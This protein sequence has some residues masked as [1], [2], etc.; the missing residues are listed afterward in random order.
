MSDP[1]R[2]AAAAL[3]QRWSLPEVGGPVIGRRIDARAATQQASDALRSALQQAEARGYEAGLARAQAETQAAMDAQAARVQHLDSILQLLATP[4]Q[5]LDAEVERDLL[6][7]TLAVGKQLARRELRIDPTQIIGIIRESL[8]QLPIAAREIRVHL[9]PE[10]AATVRDRLP[11]TTNGRAWS[12]VEDPTL[13]RGG[14]LVRTD[15]SQI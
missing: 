15:T 14:C 7:L 1:Q 9:H 3:V 10:D 6:Q 4:L 8:T 2:P 11:A 5:Q 12:I 13:T